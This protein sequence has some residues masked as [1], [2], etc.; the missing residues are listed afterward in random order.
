M[1]DLIKVYCKNDG[2]QLS[3]SLGDAPTIEDPLHLRKVFYAMPCP[4]CASVAPLV[5]IKAKVDGFT[6]YLKGVIAS[7]QAPKEDA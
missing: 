5:E 2:T 1:T 4:R 7:E 6:E 3:V